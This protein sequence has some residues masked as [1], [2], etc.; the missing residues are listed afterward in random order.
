MGAQIASD[1]ATDVNGRAMQVQRFAIQMSPVATATTGWNPCEG[2]CRTDA[3]SRGQTR[4]VPRSAGTEHASS[5]LSASRP[6]RADRS[7]RM[8]PGSTPQTSATPTTKDAR[9]FADNTTRSS[10]LNVMRAVVTQYRESKAAGPSGKRGRF[11]VSPVC[12]MRCARRVGT[13]DQ[14]P[15]GERCASARGQSLRLGWAVCSF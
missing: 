8:P 13:L 12:R 14:A 9:L 7:P 5:H 11:A 15:G 6:C 3:K 2:H 1:V 4:R 10:D